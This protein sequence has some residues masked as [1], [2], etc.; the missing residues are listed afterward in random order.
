MKLTL[1][2]PGAGATNGHSGVA[3]VLKDIPCLFHIGATQ[4]SPNQCL[5]PNIIAECT[6][7]IDHPVAVNI[8]TPP[9]AGNHQA[10]GKGTVAEINPQAARIDI[11]LAVA[12]G[13]VLDIRF[14]A[15]QVKGNLPFVRHHQYRVTGTADGVIAEEGGV[16]DIIFL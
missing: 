13:A 14:A 10:C 1:S 9:C 11:A 15:G 16:I 5:R 3:G 8:V 6:F 4:D 2:F 12:E 7:I